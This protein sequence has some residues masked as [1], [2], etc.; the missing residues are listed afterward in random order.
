MKTFEEWWT[1]HPKAGCI[2]DNEFLK[3]NIARVVW[4]AATLNTHQGTIDSVHWKVKY[5]GDDR[6]IDIVDVGYSD[7][8]IIIE[9][10]VVGS[11][12]EP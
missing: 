1:T 10:Q 2:H 4:D 12:S 7:R 5:V 3:E 6:L 9:P 8:V 11:L